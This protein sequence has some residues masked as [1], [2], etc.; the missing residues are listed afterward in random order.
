MATE[1]CE[2]CKRIIGELEQA[3]TWQSHIL[4]KECYAKVSNP[5]VAQPIPVDVRTPVILPPPQRSIVK[6]TLIVMATVVLIASLFYLVNY[7]QK[8]DQLPTLSEKDVKLIEAFSHEMSLLDAV[9]LSDKITYEAQFAKLDAVYSDLNDLGS[10]NYSMNRMVVLA[11][12]VRIY[13]RVARICWD[14][15]DTS[16]QQKWESC[17]DN[18]S[19]SRRNFV[20]AFHLLQRRTT[21]IEFNKFLIEDCF[22]G[23]LLDIKKRDEATSK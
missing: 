17:R 12:D 9:M 6:S 7:I 16:N 19:K 23:S 8:K 14:S 21:N 3:Y 15:F 22:Q 2:N 1:T 13:Y 5:T 18:A 4:C 20:K 11:L 10:T